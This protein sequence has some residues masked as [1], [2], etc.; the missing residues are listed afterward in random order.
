MTAASKG[1][2]LYTAS[3][4][5]AEGRSVSGGVMLTV[6]E[7]AERLRVRPETVRGW[8]HAGKLHGTRLPGNR[9]GWRIPSDALEQF[10][11]DGDRPTE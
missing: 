4:R 9:A 5:V 8:L 10:M 3:M 6:Q 7:V 2:T 11:R 1:R